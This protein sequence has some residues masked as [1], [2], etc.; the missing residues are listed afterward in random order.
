MAEVKWTPLMVEERLVEA[1]DVLRR[2]PDTR[3]QGYVSLW[4]PYIQESRSAE[5]TPLRRPPPSAAAITRMD[6]ALPWLR[7][8]DPTDARIVWLRAS[9]EPWKVVCW[10]VGMAR[11]AAHQHWLFA[12][13]V[14]AW[15]LDGR[16]IPRT[17]SKAALIA[18][19][20]AME[21]DG[22]ECP[23]TFPRRTDHASGG[24]VEP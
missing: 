1:A 22:E 23:R 4:P 14:I 15:T 13:C 24:K 5:D 16:R 2:L 9:G 8:L 11:S 3:L 6:E 17:I 21:K 18:R 7:L 12:L 10:K 20:R 19:A